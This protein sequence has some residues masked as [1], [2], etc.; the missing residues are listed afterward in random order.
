MIPDLIQSKLENIFWLYYTSVKI[1]NFFNKRYSTVSVCSNN[2]CARKSKHF[3]STK[4]IFCVWNE[5]RLLFEGCKS[6]RRLRLAFLRL[7]KIRK[8]AGSDYL[9]FNY[10]YINILLRN[11]RRKGKLLF[12]SEWNKKIIKNDTK[13]IFISSFRKK[14]MKLV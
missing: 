6:S 11:G 5:S 8:N 3:F 10:L 14:I 2:S 9:V 13:N 12:K 1:F 4:N 7:I